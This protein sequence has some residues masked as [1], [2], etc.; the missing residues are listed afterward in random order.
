MKLSHAIII[1]VVSKLWWQIEIASEKRC[2]IYSWKV[3]KVG[4]AAA[5]RLHERGRDKGPVYK[6]VG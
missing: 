4:R 5:S 1:I 6:Q 3:G 2:R